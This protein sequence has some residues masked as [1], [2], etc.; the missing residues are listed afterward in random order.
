MPILIA[1]ARQPESEAEAMLKRAFYVLL[2]LATVLTPVAYYSAPGWWSGLT[3]SL[4]SGDSTEA[5]DPARAA[6]ALSPSGGG[7]CRSD[8]TGPD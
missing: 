5:S 8:Q 3:A 1:A 4:S 7:E 6:L 2:P